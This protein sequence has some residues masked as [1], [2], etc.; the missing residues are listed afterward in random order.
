MQGYIKTI[1]FLL[2]INTQTSCEQ[3]DNFNERLLKVMTIN[4]AISKYNKEIKALENTR[5]E[6]ISIMEDSVETEELD[7]LIQ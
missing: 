4:Q 2:F 5:N 1:I 7:N 6:I 3:T